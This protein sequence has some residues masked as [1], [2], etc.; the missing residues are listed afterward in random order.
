MDKQ[1]RSLIGQLE[2]KQVNVLHDPSLINCFKILDLSCFIQAQA[3]RLVS[4]IHSKEIELERLSGLAQK[5]ETNNVDPNTDYTARYRGGKGSTSTEYLSDMNLKPP[6]YIS[7][8]TEA[9]QRLMFLRSSFVL[10]IL[11]LHILVFIKI[12]F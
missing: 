12:S 3:E 2:T 6:F 5:I 10:Y 1:L 9:Q 11:A 7:G 4:E 8:R